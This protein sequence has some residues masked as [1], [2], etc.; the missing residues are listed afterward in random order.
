MAAAKTALPVLGV[1]VESKALQ[2][3]DSL[4]S[5]VQMPAGDP[6][7]D[8]RD[9][10]RRRG[11]RGAARGRDRRA[12]GRG[13]ARAA[14]AR[15][16]PEQT[17][18]VLADPTPTGRAAR[19]RRRPRRRPA[20]ADARARRDPARALASAS[21][22][23]PPT[24][25]PA[26]V[27]ELLVGAYD[28]PDAARPPRRRRRGRHLRVR[29]RAGRGGAA[30]RRAARC[31]GRARGGAGPA[32]REAALP[33]ARDPDRAD[34]RRGRRAFPALPED[35]PPRLRRQGPASA[36]GRV[37]GRTLVTSSKGSSRST[38]SSR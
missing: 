15:T 25:P 3:M 26:E 19:D 4:L 8:A 33:P 36:F 11:Q 13:R 29:E 30:G 24:R 21:S 32:R 9:R 7:R 14:C 2:G 28:D 38:A 1:P 20:R 16:A 23:R 22:T 6:R 37:Q 18:S 27:G 17:A 12:L 35:A 5:I 10:P 31:A 34:R